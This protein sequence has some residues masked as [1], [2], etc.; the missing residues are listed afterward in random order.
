MNKSIEIVVGLG[1]GDEGK[2]LT[3]DWLT[4]KRKN[5][6]VVR[7]NSGAQA[8]HTVQRE[9]GIRHVFHHFGSGTFNGASTILSR[10]FVVNPI[11]FWH[12]AMDLYRKC[13]ILPNMYVDKDCLVTTPYDVYINQTIEKARDGERHGSCGVGFG[14]T[15]ERAERGFALKVS[16]LTDI[17]TLV[18]KLECIKTEYYPERLKELGIEDNP[19]LLE[20]A[21]ERFLKDAREFCSNVKICKDTEAFEIFEHLV[22]EGAQ[23]LFLDQDSVDFPHVTRS[24]TGLT[25]V[26]QLIDGIRADVDVYYITRTYLSRH[27]AGPLLN[28]IND[29][30]GIVDKTNVT[31]SWQGSLRFA[32]LN[33]DKM[34]YA[35]E[36][37]ML[38]FKDIDCTV[39]VMITHCDQSGIVVPES[40]DS[41]ID[42]VAIATGAENVYTCWGPTAADVK[43]ERTG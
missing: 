15:I 40:L 41:I 5:C 10:F 38:N 18:E 36:E 28:E 39:N 20:R 13:G 29:V 9:D 30:T 33:Y 1:Y 31:N 26:K 37:D 4:R 22:F 42:K 7:F 2:G 34:Q 21:D 12:E 19:I 14:E 43:M 16:D 24:N 17:D 3:T 23:G 25:N 6:A 27:G 8:G 32:P 35:I 11:L